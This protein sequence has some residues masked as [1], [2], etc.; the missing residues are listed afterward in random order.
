MNG[1]H[2]LACLFI[3]LAAFFNVFWTGLALPLVSIIAAGV[4][5]ICSVSP[6]PAQDDFDDDI[7]F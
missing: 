5:I 6:A 1:W 3:A 4:A 2:I 7:P